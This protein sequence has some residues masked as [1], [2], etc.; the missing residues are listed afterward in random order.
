MLVTITSYS[1]LAWDGNGNPLP[2]SGM[3]NRIDCQEF[4][5]AG[6]TD[7]LEPRTRLVRVA[8]DTPVRINFGGD[9]DSGPAE[10][11]MPGVEHFNVRGGAVLTIS[12][13]A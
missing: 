1:H 5:A 13:V 11:V 3:V 6:E 7:P 10:L 8:T 4:T 9:E 12:E 2:A